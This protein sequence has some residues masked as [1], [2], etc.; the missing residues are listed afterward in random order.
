VPLEETPRVLDDL[1]R[2][3]DVRYVGTSNLRAWQL[4]DAP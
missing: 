1:V 4:M 3:G 2:V